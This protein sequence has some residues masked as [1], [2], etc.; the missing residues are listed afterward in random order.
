MDPNRRTTRNAARLAAQRQHLNPHSPAHSATS[1][2]LH[3]ASPPPPFTPAP[4]SNATPNVNSTISVQMPGSFAPPSY[5]NTVGASLTNPAS[6]ATAS[7]MNP[8]TQNPFDLQ[9][10]SQLPRSPNPFLASG[11]SRPSSGMSNIP[12]SPFPSQ[13]DANRRLLQTTTFTTP[14]ISV[15]VTIRR[16]ETIPE[17]SSQSAQES[18]QVGD[19][20]EED[21]S[22]A[23]RGNE[24]LGRVATPIRSINIDNG[25]RTTTRSVPTNNTE[26]LSRREDSD[27]GLEYT[28]SGRGHNERTESVTRRESEQRASVHL[29]SA[30]VNAPLVQDPARPGHFSAAV[31]HL[32]EIRGPLTNM[33]QTETPERYYF[34]FPACKI[35]T[36][37]D[38]WDETAQRD[39]ERFQMALQIASA[40][41]DRDI[42]WVEGA[43]KFSRN[44]RQLLRE[45]LQ[46][47]SALFHNLY[48]SHNGRDHGYAI[49]PAIYADLVK[50]A[51]RLRRET[52]DG[53]IAAGVTI[54]AIPR[55]GPDGNIRHYWSANDFEI[56]AAV[57][58]AEME[59]YFQNIFAAHQQLA[60]MELTTTDRQRQQ[61]INLT[62]PNQQTFTDDNDAPVADPVHTQDNA[63]MGQDAT[64]IVPGVTE[65]PRFN[66]LTPVALRE[67][68]QGTVEPTLPHVR[69]SAPV[70]ESITTRVP[71]AQRRP[72][73]TNNVLTS[74]F[75]YVPRNTNNNRLQET[76][77]RGLLH[78]RVRTG[79]GDGGDDD[80]S[81]SSDEE[82]GD[83]NSRRN[84]GRREN[85][86]DENPDFLYFA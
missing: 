53:F 36:E 29:V 18:L 12:T 68:D 42:L 54:P 37:H 23:S 56:I 22:I 45:G 8:V 62:R 43:H 80:P 70:L 5:V 24:S 72:Q 4:A 31:T 25:I 77:G 16:A 19:T 6:A 51:I 55:W 40:Y 2:S 67:L 46:R 11:I 61:P 39:H 26:D 1:E 73:R 33:V 69:Q 44:A 30:P 74:A 52:E 14:R 48:R 63:T 86:G 15:P 10:R 47:L 79:G 20:G 81:S 57:Y 41:F 34:T 3:G 58:R 65:G 21:Q 50:E 60:R 64:N 38:R 85:P 9:G 78:S 17:E 28:D 66:I 59:I 76:F 83:N 7:T 75:G 32:H 27:E 13:L 71:A 84:S 82:G 49:D 35:F